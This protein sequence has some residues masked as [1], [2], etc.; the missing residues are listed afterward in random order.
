MFKQADDGSVIIG[1]SHEYTSVDQNAELD[2]GINMEINDLIIAEAKRIL[3]LPHY[4][5]KNYWAGLYANAK[6]GGIYRHNFDQKIHIITGIGGKG[7]TCG[8]GY[9]KSRIEKIFEK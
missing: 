4:L 9:A 8:P 1:D 2:F 6:S 5:I 7:M 3:N